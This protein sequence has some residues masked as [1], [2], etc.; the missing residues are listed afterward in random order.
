MRSPQSDKERLAKYFAQLG[1]EFPYITKRDVDDA[2]LRPCKY[3]KI[4][5]E[6]KNNPDAAG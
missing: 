1:R 5:E 2:L 3:C 4:L 6:K